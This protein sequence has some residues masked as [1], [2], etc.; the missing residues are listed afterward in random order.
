MKTI[1]E[2][3]KERNYNKAELIEQGFD[4]NIIV[5][6]DYI[7]YLTTELKGDKNET[8]I[9]GKANTGIKHKRN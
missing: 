4:I 2:F 9:S 5:L 7:Y 8:R 6:A 3:I 1:I